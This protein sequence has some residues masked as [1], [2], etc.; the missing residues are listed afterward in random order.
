MRVSICV[1]YLSSLH[2]PVQVYTVPYTWSFPLNL[3]Q[4]FFGIFPSGILTTDDPDVPWA[5]EIGQKVFLP[6]PIGASC[7][8]RM[9]G[10][11]LSLY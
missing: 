3:P 1:L 4:Q 7:T 11:C 10:T 5:D 6:P 8:S 9:H 2:P